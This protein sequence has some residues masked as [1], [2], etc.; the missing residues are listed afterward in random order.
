[1]INAANQDLVKAGTG[2]AESAFGLGC[3]L[4]TIV[5]LLILVVVLL[6]GARN[7]ILLAILA[8]GIALVAAGVSALI[9]TRAKSATMGA[10]YD[11]QVKAQIDGY[12]R[13]TGITRQEFDS[14]VNEVLQPDAPLRRYRS[15]PFEPDLTTS[16][17]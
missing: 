2:A 4:G 7:W 3:S 1:L 9:S 11:R 14:L 6:L 12:V 15:T 10:T 17:N 16:E 13:T 8:M 5:G